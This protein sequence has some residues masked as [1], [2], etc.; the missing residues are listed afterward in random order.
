MKTNQLP[1][2]I[3]TLLFTFHLSAATKYWTNSNGTNL[4]HDAGNWTPAGIP[5]STDDVQFNATYSTDDCTIDADATIDWVGL[6]AGYTGTVTQT[7]RSKFTSNNFSVRDGIWD[8]QDGNFHCN[9]N[10]N[11]QGGT[12]TKTTGRF[13]CLWMDV[14]S[15][16]FYGGTSG[17]VY[18]DDNF[19]GWGSYPAGKL[20]IHGGTVDLG[21]S[22]T[23]IYGWY[24]QEGGHFV[25]SSN[26]TRVGRYYHN[27]SPGV[28]ASISPQ[29]FTIF[30]KKGG[31]FDPNDGLFYF[32]AYS[33]DS[34]T[35]ARIWLGDATFYDLQFWG[36]TY[37]SGNNQ[38]FLVLDKD[39][40]FAENNLTHS[41]AA[42]D[43]TVAFK[44][45]LR[46]YSNARDVGRGSY[47]M[48]GS[49]DQHYYHSGSNKGKKLVVDKTGGIV[50]PLNVN[51]PSLYLQS[52]ELKNGH[53]ISSGPS[54]EF[55]I[56]GN[57]TANNTEFFTIRAG[58][59]FDPNGGIVRFRP[60]VNY[61]RIASIRHNGAT[62]HDVIVDV[63]PNH[64][65]IPRFETKDGNLVVGNNLTHSNGE[66]ISN[67]D[68]YG[69]FYVGPNA[70]KSNGW[71][72]FI[73]TNDQ[74]YGLT[75]AAANSCAVLV[76]KTTGKVLPNATADGFRMSRFML[77]NGE[78]VAPSGLMQINRYNTSSVDIFNH[79]GGIFTANGGTVLFNPVYHN[80]FDGRLFDIHVQPTTE[81]YNVIL[82]MNR[83]DS[84]EATLRMQGG[85]LIAHGDVTFRDGQFTGDIQVGGNIDFSN[86][87][88]LSFTGSVDF[89]DSNPQ[90]Y[91]LGNALGGEL[92][93]IDV[94]KTGGIATGDPANT[95][96]SAWNIRVYSGTFE[97]PSGILTLGENLN[98]GGIYNSLYTAG[99][100]AITHNGSGKVICKGSRNIQYTANG[101][102]SLYDLEIDKGAAEIRILNGD[103]HIANEL[104][105]LGSPS[106]Y[107]FDNALYTKD[108]V[109]NGTMYFDDN[110]SLVQTQGGTF[111]G[112]GEIDYQRIG[113]T[114]NTGFSLWSSPVANAD[115]FQVFEHSNQCVL[116]GFDQAQQLWRFDLQPGQPL[117]CA[118]FPTMNATWSMGP[119]SG[120]NV[121]GLMD[122]GLGYAATGSTL[123]NDSIRTFVGEP[124]NG[125]IAVPVKTTSVVHTVWV[126][127]DWGLVGNPY[128]SAIGMNEFWQ[129]NAISNARIKGGLYFLV[130]RPGQ[131]I[132]QYDDYAV[133]NSIGFLDPSNSP[134][135]GDNGNIGAS[136]GFWVDANADGTVLFDNYMR[137]GT[138]DVFYKRGII[139]GNH[140]DARVWISLKNSSFTSNQILTGMKAD[141]TM[142]MDGPYD[143]RQA[144][145]TMLPPV[146]LFS[147]VDSVPCVIQGI[148][149]VKS[150]QRRTV[151]LYVHTVYDGLFDFQVNRME[152]FQGH[153]L[154]IEDRVKGTMNEL[155]HGSTYQ[156]RMMSGDYED[157]FYLVFDGNGHNDDG[158]V[159]NIANDQHHA[160]PS[161]FSM[162]PGLNAYNNQGF[163]VIDASTS[164]QNIQKVE[165]FDL[166]GRLLYNNNGLSI[167]ML[168]I[169][170][171]EF[172]NGLYLVSVQMS[173]GQ[174]YTT[175]VPTLN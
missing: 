149:T 5:A 96:L 97:L 39:T 99:S 105:L 59:T 58:T 174:G 144:Y 110:G 47:Y 4:W 64:G 30:T 124:N 11:I 68:L 12:T 84:R 135:I 53:F 66:I 101:S 82:D 74:Y 130:D 18:I 111:S 85:P 1:L 95:D 118:G 77:V 73:G 51:S 26:L 88:T 15:G 32:Y 131:N 157:R 27:C 138:N 156:L 6:I 100:G 41:A 46:I 31:T 33:R 120:Y 19:N 154:Y 173:D 123:A 23:Y 136:Q 63:R 115:L 90:T 129:E 141:A 2:L 16:N 89:I 44:G 128:P 52:F 21:G 20:H 92:K 112:T 175:I 75:G 164:E 143:A 140:P 168:E 137:K 142:G 150:G 42:I 50:S 10:G 61:N 83:S 67:I 127:S 71:V 93:Y 167:N 151:P 152:N 87:N 70:D 86:A 91:H 134:G 54:G 45:D 146:A 65:N 147:M 106:F 94:H 37:F 81:F 125:P 3:I 34:W 139:G 43:A 80:R 159:I 107:V 7:N 155:T 17:Q 102:I 160:N 69:N 24:I 165:V 158:S 133:Y 36:N 161:V 117:N 57:F 25:A 153:K 148:P 48:Y 72:R 119:G 103:I 172:S 126:G 35:N 40:I 13:R 8:I 28:P 162:A 145:G 79:N 114:E 113:I 132:H 14:Y 55:S 163:L 56:G 22:Y 166:T 60:N 121:D 104:K 122:P 108:L 116:Y 78:F 109:L 170:T 171:A 62:F 49:R 98:S 38:D 169:P 76:S 9:G 29:P